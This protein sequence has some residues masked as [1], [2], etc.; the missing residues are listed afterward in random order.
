MTAPAAELQ[1]PRWENSRV[2]VSAARRGASVSV[3]PA[4]TTRTLRE[5]LPPYRVILHNDDVHS[6]DHVVR[7]LLASVPLTE[8][9][10]TEIMTEAHNHGQAEVVRCPLELAELYRE[11]LQS[12]GL[13]ATIE[14]V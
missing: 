12:F 1:A 9:R 6:M 5:T 2:R 7:A 14:R 10:A 8:A 11:R 4:E 13:T 3:L